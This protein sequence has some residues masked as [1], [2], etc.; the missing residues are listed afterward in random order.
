MS[1]QIQASITGK[2]ILH[3]FFQTKKGD[4]V[5]FFHQQKIAKSASCYKTYP[6]SPLNISL[7]LI[8]DLFVTFPMLIDPID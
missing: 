5:E 4:K 2:K 1:L 7:V 3:E 6:D 8:I